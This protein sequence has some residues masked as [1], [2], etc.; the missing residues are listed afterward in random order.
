MVLTK[1]VEG[2]G[3][4]VRGKIKYEYRKGPTRLSETKAVFHTQKITTITP[5]S[6]S[7]GG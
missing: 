4:R 5:E 7:Q 3:R 1:I 2:K 6:K